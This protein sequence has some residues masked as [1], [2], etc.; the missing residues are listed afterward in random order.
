[1]KAD[2]CY[3]QGK[4]KREGCIIQPVASVFEKSAVHFFMKTLTVFI[5]T[6]RL[7]ILNAY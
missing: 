3:C 4:G 7:S 6:I 5:Y 1:M 2:Y